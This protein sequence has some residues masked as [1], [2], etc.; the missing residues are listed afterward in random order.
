MYKT[1]FHISKMDCPSEEQ[2]IRMKLDGLNDIQSM[3]FDIPARKL[4]V[5]HTH[6]HAPIFERLDS[7]NFNTTIM[8][9]HPVDTP[10]AGGSQSVERKLLWQ[11]LAINFFFFALEMT[12]GLISRS[13]GLIADSLDM[14][15]DSLVYG[16]ALMAVGR[17]V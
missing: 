3:Q 17:T 2:M 8:E 11:V 1:V 15:A 13:M 9:S 5:Y 10:V 6:S 16:L 4:S 7:L 12:T 14:L